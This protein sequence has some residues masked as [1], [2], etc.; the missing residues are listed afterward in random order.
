MIRVVLDTN[1]ILSSL[2]QPHGP[3]AK[4]LYLARRGL[5]ELCVSGPVYAEYEEVLQ[6]PRFQRVEPAI[7][8]TLQ[9]IRESGF[10]VRPVT[11]LR[12]CNDP[13]DDIFLE[14]A[15]A[16]GA[17]WLVTGNVRDFPTDWHGAGIVTPRAFLDHLLALAKRL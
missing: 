1:I 10:W 16:A 12:V 17:S 6:R 15:Q 5:L 9:F 3:P 14:C 7:G 4:V 2:L 13:D 8:P 11:S